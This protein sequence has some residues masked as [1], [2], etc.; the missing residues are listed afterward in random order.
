MRIV[1]GSN[2]SFVSFQGSS[3][4]VLGEVP[5]SS[6]DLIQYSS[7]SLYSSRPFVSSTFALFF[8]FIFVLS[9]FIPFIVTSSF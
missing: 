5:V 3:F 4:S 1:I 9:R 8:E 6:R 2:F 7:L